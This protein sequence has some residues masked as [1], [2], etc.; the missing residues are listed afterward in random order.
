METPPQIAVSRLER[1]VSAVVRPPGSK[2]FTNRALIA[3][4]LASGVSRLHDPLEAEDTEAMRSGLRDF[5]VAIDDNDDPWL[6]LGTDGDLT[7]PTIPI[8]GGLSGTTTRFLSAMAALANGSVTVTGRG[9]MLM[10]PFDE[11]VAALTVAGVTVTSEDGHLPVEVHGTG[12]LTGGTIPVDPSRSSQFVSALLLIAPMAEGEVDLILT[13]APVS[14]PYLSST[15]EVM[16]AFGADVEDLGD[17][18]RIAPTG[19]RSTQYAIEADASAAAYPLVAAAITG[20]RIGIEGI[21]ITSVQPDLALVRVL[22]SMGCSVRRMTHRLDLVGPGSLRP[23]DVDMN[24]APDAVLALASACLFAEG[25]SRIRNVGN[26]RLKESDRLAAV[27]TEIRRLGGF[28]QTEGND[29]IVGPGDLHGAVVQT[30]DDHRVAMAFALVGLRVP[31]V[32][33]ENPAVV[34]KTWPGYFDLLAHL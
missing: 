8:D 33:I 20:G 13:Q 32:I 23:V 34:G 31:G 26:L 7:V 30:Y 22:E 11:L 19:Y 28:A 14:R 15:V 4:A 1:P 6:I 29:L 9:R 5:G 12:H 21:P 27:T 18:F 17:R 24:D 2:S 3:A 25:K 16:K 10:R